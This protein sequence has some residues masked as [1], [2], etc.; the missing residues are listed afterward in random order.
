MSEH[1]TKL[2][3]QH[4][5]H[6]VISIFHTFVCMCFM[7]Q[8]RLIS[9]THCHRIIL[10]NKAQ[11]PSLSKWKKG[12][13]PKE[14][15]SGHSHCYGSQSHRPRRDH[16]SSLLPYMTKCAQRDWRVCKG[17]LSEEYL[18]E[19]SNWEKHFF[20][21]KEAVLAQQTTFS[22]WAQM[23]IATRVRML[24]SVTGLATPSSALSFGNNS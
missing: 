23:Q 17:I 13:I 14:K 7:C 6:L 4:P 10:C 12:Q 18:S 19:P 11:S 24:V 8:Q 22:S 16:D 5:S 2:K 3:K 20:T 21:S 1:L 9:P 15:S